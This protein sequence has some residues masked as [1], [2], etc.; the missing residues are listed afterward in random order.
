[1]DST[2]HCSFASASSSAALQST[3][4]S[5]L[6]ELMGSFESEVT[7]S[8]VSTCIALVEKIA[9][10]AQ[11]LVRGTDLIYAIQAELPIPTSASELPPAGVLG[12][13]INLITIVRHGEE[14]P[15]E[16]ILTAFSDCGVDF[17]CFPGAYD[18]E[19]QR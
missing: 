14:D 4:W 1:M 16:C 9:S 17:I 12:V 11:P 2:F 6:T 7:T 3:I 5:R 18:R 19:S 10:K 15:I 8:Y 13:C